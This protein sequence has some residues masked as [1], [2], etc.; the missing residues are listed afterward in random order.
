VH[1]SRDT[2]T[3]ESWA[4]E[5]WLDF[6]TAYTYDD[7]Y[8]AVAAE[9]GRPERKPVLM[10]ESL[11]EGEHGTGEQLT[12]KSA[13][14]AMLAGAAGQVFGNNPIWHFNGPG[15]QHSWINWQAALSSGGSRSM[16]YFR[17]F[18]DSLEW[19]KLVADNGRMLDRRVDSNRSAVAGRAT[20]GS[21]AVVYLSSADPV[22]LDL[23]QLSGT[24]AARW[25]DPTSGEFTDAQDFPNSAPQHFSPPE[26]LNRAGFTDWLLLLMSVG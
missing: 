1:S 20:D 18:F 15:V 19:W 2:V 10:I 16:T 21:F 22:T 3:S 13:Y 11:Y 24:T 12:R 9:T 17:Q 5:P 7:V 23:S 14:E 6:D 25:F 8:A 4:G 26:T